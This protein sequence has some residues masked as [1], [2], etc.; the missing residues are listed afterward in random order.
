MTDLETD[1]SK[2]S[3]YTAIYGGTFAPP[4][5]GHIRAALALMEM[6]NPRE[7]YLMPTSIPP[8][9]QFHFTDSPKARKEMLNLCFRN[10]QQF[11]KHLFVSDYELNRK[12]VSYTYLTLE[13]FF[14]NVNNKLIFLCGA[15]MFVTLDTW[16]NAP[17]IFELADIAYVSRS[18]TEGIEECANRFIKDYRARIIHIP[19]ECADISSTELRSAIA[20]GEDTSKWLLPEVEDYI[21]KHRIYSDSRNG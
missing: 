17:R 15:D 9:K 8:H 20:S 3:D 21:R 16:R 6:L 10:N 18:G 14:V 4:H 7:L 19:I 13:H 5:I 1:I 11:G 2:Y 12:R